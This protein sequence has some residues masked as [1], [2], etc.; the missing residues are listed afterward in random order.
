MYQR[1]LDKYLTPNDKY[2][3]VR[4]RFFL[5]FA[6]ERVNYIAI[7]NWKTMLPIRLPHFQYNP[8]ALD[9]KIILKTETLCPVCNQ[10]RQYVYDGPFYS[11]EDADG[12]CP[13]CIKDGSAAKK[14]DGEFQDPAS[15]EDVINDEYVTELTRRTPG[16]N[17]WQDAKW[18]GHCNDFCALKAYAGWNEIK[19]FKD[20]LFNDI[21]DLTFEFGMGFQDF[22][23]RLVNGGYFQGYLFQ[24]LHCGKHRLTADMN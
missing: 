23:K 3:E 22:T 13:W 11:V 8:N 16:Y 10:Q 21:N 1:A 2:H 5:S 14:Y 18:L 15:C 4:S 20:E 17:A 6:A 7:T 19:E 12:I 9:L 24:C